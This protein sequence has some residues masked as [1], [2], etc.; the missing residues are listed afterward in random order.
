MGRAVGAGHLPRS[1]FK[2]SS[3]KFCSSPTRTRLNT[4]RWLKPPATPTPRPWRCCKKQERS[5]RPIS[6]IGNAFCLT[7]FPK[8][9]QF[10]ALQAPAIEA[11]CPQRMC[12]RIR[13][14][15]R[16]PPR[17]TTPCQC[18]AWARARSLWA[19][20]L[21]HRAWRSR[22]DSA[23]DQLGRQR[24]STVYMPGYKI[25]ML[26]DEVVQ[27]YTLQEGRD[28]PAVSLYVTFDEATPCNNNRQ[29][30]ASGACADCGQLAT[31]PTRPCGHA[32]L[33]R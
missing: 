31:R 4:K 25:T 1:R 12:R 17:L 6:F 23:I 5:R 19:F 32:S 24:L 33:V 22:P 27:S 11:I 2:R 7:T 26:P 28:C 20:T 3:T 14:T 8:G 21:R 29:R 13:L 15:I 10:P 9:T 30:D 16:K 18:K